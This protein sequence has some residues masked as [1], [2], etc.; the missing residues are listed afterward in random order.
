MMLLG[1]LIAAGGFALRI[2]TGSLLLRLEKSQ[3]S[4]LTEVGMTRVDWQLSCLVGIFRLAF[5]ERRERISRMDRS[6]L[7][8]FSLF[9][10]ALLAFGISILCKAIIG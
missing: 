2:L 9:Y 7:Q 1:I 3:P 4:L 8:L 10:L 6:V 5:G